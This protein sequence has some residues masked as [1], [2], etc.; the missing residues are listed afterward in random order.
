[1]LD[2]KHRSSFQMMQNSLDKGE[3][4]AFIYY[5]FDLIYYDEW[6]IT[7]LPLIERKKILQSF[8]PQNDPMLR[9][10]D[11]IGGF[12]DEVFN[13]A[14]E[15]SLEGI[16]SKVAMSPYQTR[17]TKTWL[18]IKCTKRQ[19]FVIGGFTPPKGARTHFGSLYLGY[20]DK[21]GE[22]IFCG[23]VGTGFTSSSLRDIAK[24]L[25]KRI[26]TVGQAFG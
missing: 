5:L 17:R 9:Y 11:H 6:D 26:V 25:Q 19:E 18:K 22:L 4:G 1:M 7:S 13:N 21:K 23:N 8:L 15:L 3:R 24:E 14:C 16:I 10:S 12:G 20:Y 2:E